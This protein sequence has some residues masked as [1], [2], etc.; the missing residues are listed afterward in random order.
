MMKREQGVWQGKTGHDM[1]CQGCAV[2]QVLGHW[3]PTPKIL[4]QSQVS[5][6]ICNG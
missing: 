2:A 6:K 5:L 1:K 3:A 4:V